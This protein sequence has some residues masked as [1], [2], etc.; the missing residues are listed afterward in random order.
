[1]VARYK[2]P[3]NC[4]QFFWREHPRHLLN[5]SLDSGTGMKSKI[6]TAIGAL[7]SQW[8][9]VRPYL[10]EN[11]FRYEIDRKMLASRQE[12]EDVADRV[13]SLLERG[14][15]VRSPGAAKSRIVGH[16]INY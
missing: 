15:A 8:H 14:G 3:L 4:K 10:R 11:K 16:L 2:F 13:Y 1:V 5:D 9:S 12:L 7:K 6:D